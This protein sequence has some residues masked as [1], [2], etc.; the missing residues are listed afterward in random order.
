MPGLVVT[1]PPKAG[2]SAPPPAPASPGARQAKPAKPAKAATV[3]DKKGSD[4][5]GAAGKAGQSIILIVNDEPVTQYEVLQ[6]ARLLSLNGIGEKAQENFKRLAQSEDTNRRFRAIIEDIVRANQGKS[7]EHIIGLI[8]ARKKVF[9]QSLQ[10]QA[11]E[12]ARGAAVLRVTKE[13]QEEIIEE[14]LK[15]Q[16]ARRL[17]VEVSDDDVARVIKGLAAQN[18]VSEAQFAQN[19]AR[20]GVD[21]S[22]MKARYKANLSWRDVI[23]RRFSTQISVQQRDIDR[24]LATSSAATPDGG[25]ELH[26]QK[27]TY[28]LPARIDQLAMAKALAEADGARRKFTSCKSMPQIAAATPGATY[29][30]LKFVK[31]SSLSEPARSLVANAKDGEL[32]PPQTGTKGVELYAVCERRQIKSDDKRRDEAAQELQSQQFEQLAKKH[33]RDLRQDAHI[34]MR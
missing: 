21:I 8:E 17:G 4:Q 33:L 7:R 24:L 25:Q 30:D 12:S 27:I 10:Q 9:A 29:E 28:P 11:L 32:L 14:K 15:L 31:A 22:T 3:D 5:G 6:R 20:M 19:L 16:E 23:R 13:A 26:I 18:K 1:A 34:E 2:A